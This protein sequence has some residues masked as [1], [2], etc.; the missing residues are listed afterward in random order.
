MEKFWIVT[1]FHFRPDETLRLRIEQVGMEQFSAL[2][3]E[4]F[5]LTEAEVDEILGE[6][7]YS[8]GDVPETV[9]DEVEESVRSQSAHYRFFFDSQ[10]AAHE[11]KNFCQREIL[12]EVQL[13]EQ[14]VQD[15][16]AEWKKHY[17]PIYVNDQFEVIPAWMQEY[18]S[19]SKHSLYINPG[20][21]FGTGSHETTFLCLQL[22]TENLNSKISRVLDFGSG[23]GI[24]GLA[25]LK[26]YPEAEIDFYDID[27]EANKNCF[28]NAE[29]NGLENLSFRLVLPEVRD[30]LKKE[31]D[32][33]FANILESILLMEQKYLAHVT[34]PGGLL[35]LSGLLNHQVEGIVKTYE[36]LGM[37]L[38]NHLSKGDWSALSFKRQTV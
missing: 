5:S 15:W 3:I 27:P 37:K 10:S 16:N 20:M 38:I 12:A 26:F 32:L 34:S 13:E 33:V 30:V 23:S 25:S 28:Q 1:L 29:L 31:Y 22:L 19:K 21:G 7:A 2:G 35:I 14:T 8:G 36:S 11:F 24:L 9:L 6:R 4:E 17:S 18:K